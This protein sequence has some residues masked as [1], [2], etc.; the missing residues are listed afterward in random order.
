[1]GGGE[2]AGAHEGFDAAVEARGDTPPVFEAEHAPDDGALLVDGLVVSILGFVVLARRDDRS[3]ASCIQ[4][5]MP[6]LTVIALIRAA[7]G[8]R[9]H[10]RDA[11]LRDLAILDVEFGVAAAFGAADTMSQGPPFPPPAQ[12]WT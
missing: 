3:C 4:P 5:F 7:F 10:G 9:R 12:R 11:T 1:M 2:S 6:G 8:R